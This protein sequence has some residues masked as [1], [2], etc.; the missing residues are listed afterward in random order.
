MKKRGEGKTKKKQRNRLR[1]K[2]LKQ[3][4]K[5]EKKQCSNAVPQEF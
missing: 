1:C 3:E 5:K 4:G 2:Y